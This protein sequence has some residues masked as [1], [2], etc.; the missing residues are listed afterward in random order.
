MFTRCLTDRDQ[1]CEPP[2][3]RSLSIA[4][5]FHQVVPYQA[6]A[7]KESRG[8]WA[9]W[10]P[11]V[12]FIRCPLAGIIMVIAF[13]DVLT[14]LVVAL[15]IVAAAWWVS[16]KLEHRVARNDLKRT[17]AHSSRRTSLPGEDVQMAAQRKHRQELRERAPRLVLEARRVLTVSLDDDHGWPVRH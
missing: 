9:I 4:R 3:N 11:L 7:P 10:F 12:A 15:A 17:P 1:M 2:A 8:G 6:V 13:G 5:A 14:L 16:R